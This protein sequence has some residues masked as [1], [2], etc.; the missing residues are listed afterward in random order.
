MR[1]EAASFSC[2]VLINKAMQNAEILLTK[3]FNY[4][5]YIKILFAPFRTKSGR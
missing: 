3:Y 4:Q 5:D 1:A 2:E